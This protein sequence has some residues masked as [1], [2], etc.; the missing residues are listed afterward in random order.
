M[1]FDTAG[2]PILWE[3]YCI[4]CTLDTGGSHQ[5]WCPISQSSVYFKL[6]EQG[7]KEIE[8]GKFSPKP[9]S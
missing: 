2:N 3:D 7:V 5:D 6:Y 1:Q 9:G 8:E 4:Y